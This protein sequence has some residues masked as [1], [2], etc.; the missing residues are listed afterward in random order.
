MF[1]IEE[2]GLH[3][4]WLSVLWVASIALSNVLH[5]ADEVIRDQIVAN[6][7]SRFLKTYEEEL[8]RKKEKRH[9]RINLPTFYMYTSKQM[10][11]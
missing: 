3:D 2:F 5:V 7:N 6:N 8:E 9:K 11:Y 4:R 10:I 1:N